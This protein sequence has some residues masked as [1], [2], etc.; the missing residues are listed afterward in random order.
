MIKNNRV[1]FLVTLIFFAYI[2]C[3][4]ILT[5]LPDSSNITYT[6]TYNIIPLTSIDEFFYDIMA[7]GIINWAFLSMKPTG[8]LDIVMY[9]FTDSFKNLMGNILIFIPLGLLYP[10]CRKKNGGFFGAFLIILGSTCTIEI[11]Q[12]FFLTSRRAD[13]DDIIL[14]VIG[15]IIGYLIYKWIK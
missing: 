3:L 6:N 11:L 7:N 14:N 12:F 1:R 8:F 9:T 15:G 10:L 2:I 13:V 5:L 4:I